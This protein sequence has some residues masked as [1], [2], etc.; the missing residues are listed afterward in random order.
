MESPDINALKKWCKDEESFKK[1]KSLVENIVDKGNEFEKRLN[2][3]ESAVRS[4]Y[5][6]IIITELS[7]EKPGPRIVYVNDGFCEMTGYSKEEVIGKT[8]RILQGPKTDRDMLDKLKRRLKEGQS[9]FGQAINYRKDG[10]EFVN[11]WDIHP[12]TDKEGNVTHWVSYQHDITERKRVEEQLVDEIVEFDKLREESKRTVVDVDVQGN[13]VMAN[14]AFREL[15][16]YGKDELKQIKIWDLFPDKYMDSIKERFDKEDEDAYFNDEEFKGIINHK[17]GFPTQIKGT[18]S[19]LDL[20]DQKLI[21]TEIE[22]I[23][24]KKRVMDTLKKRNRNFDRVVR[25]ASEF[26]YKVE[27]K[28]EKPVFKTVSEE[29]P[30]IMG[31]SADAVTGKLEA[32]KFIH[33]DDLDKFYAHLQKVFEGKNSTCEYSIKNKNGEFVEVLDYAKPEW[34]QENKNVV[35][36][37]C[38]VSV[39]PA[40]EQSKV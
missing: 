21:R 23:S 7:L 9:F 32:D 11:Q 14:K 3:L 35:R 19:I 17:S 26:S 15:V 5:D 10:S 4:D 33:E 6:S 16:G 34:D 31:L 22:N 25:K 38:V 1:V 28:D 12:L 20:K 39:D 24:L 8:P 36:V 18:T 2:L 13:I 30:E 40:Y 27:L 29:F 37:S